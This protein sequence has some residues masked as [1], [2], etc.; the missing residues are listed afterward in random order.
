MSTESTSP[1]AAPRRGRKKEKK[2][3]WQ[4]D[5]SSLGKKGEGEAEEV[6]EHALFVPSLPQVNLLPKEVTDAIAI[7]RIRRAFL[8]AAVLLVAAVAGVWWLQGSTIADAEADL[9]AATT[10]NTELRQDLDAL[11]PVQA[12]YDQI[13][14]LQSVV[15]TTLAS[16]PQASLV[17]ERLA[18]A[19]DAVGG[20]PA[21][22]FLSANVTYSGIPLPGEDLNACP[23]PDPFG[24]EITIGCL[25]FT[26]TAR[27]REQVS[28]LLRELEADPIFI[29][30]YVTS[31]TA[32]E[33]AGVGG[34]PGRTVVAFSGS[35]GV[36]L[37]ALQTLL[38]PEQ[39]EAIM[40]PPQPEPAPTATDEGGEG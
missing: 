10:Q 16:Q 24:T 23:S 19:G 20:S 21:V 8:V 2:S 4:I 14:S 15:T 13:T 12:M 25:N 38:T 22:S 31:T 33:V 37:K 7:G 6:V 9:A 34:G 35:A 3:L 28:S 27:D 11:A 32:T 30:P 40:T 17:L 26:A 18:E 39:I 5:V 1:P 29:G 36:S